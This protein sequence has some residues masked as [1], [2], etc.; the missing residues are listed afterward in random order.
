MSYEHKPIALEVSHEE[1]L[2]LKSGKKGFYQQDWKRIPTEIELIDKNDGMGVVFEYP[3]R[4]DMKKTDHVI[5]AYTYPFNLNDVDHSINAVQNKCL[6]NDQ[7]YFNK[8]VLTHSLE[9]R[10]MHQITLAS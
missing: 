9:G 6:A 8:K 5:F 3:V 10:P 7:I 4:K 1:F 2:E